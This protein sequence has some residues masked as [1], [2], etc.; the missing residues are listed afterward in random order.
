[1]RLRTRGA[2]AGGEEARPLNETATDVAT[3][4]GSSGFMDLRFTGLGVALSPFP[5]TCSLSAM[6]TSVTY[7]FRQSVRLLRSTG[8]YPGYCGKM[9]CSPGCRRKEG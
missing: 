6:P 8:T 5:P 7:Q 1:M 9:P 4:S 3:C 2:G